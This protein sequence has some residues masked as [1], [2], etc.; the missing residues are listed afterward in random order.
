MLPAER[1]LAPDVEARYS[2]LDDL[3]DAWRGVSGFAGVRV[4]EQLA[5]WT[6]TEEAVGWLELGSPTK[7]IDLFENALE[8]DRQS[9]V[10]EAGLRRAFE[11]IG[12][13][14]GRVTSKR[15]SPG[16]PSGRHTAEHVEPEPR[17]RSVGPKPEEKGQ[18]LEA[19]RAFSE[20]LVMYRHARL[21]GTSDV[22]HLHG[23]R[24]L[25][26]SAR[27][28][29][30]GCRM[31]AASACRPIRSGPPKKRA[32]RRPLRPSRGSPSESPTA[33]PSKR[34]VMR[35]TG[36]VKHDACLV[37]I[38]DSS[39]R[40]SLRLTGCL[41]AQRSRVVLAPP[42]AIIGARPP[43]GHGHEHRGHRSPEVATENDSHVVLEG[44]GRK[45]NKLDQGAS[46]RGQLRT[47]R[48]AGDVLLLRITEQSIGRDD[49]RGVADRA[50]VEHE[51]QTPAADE[52]LPN[53]SIGE[54][55]DFVTNEPCPESPTLQPVMP[56]ESRDTTTAVVW[57]CPSRVTSRSSASI[58]P[59]QSV[60]RE[61]APPRR[62][63]PVRQQHRYPC[64]LPR[65]PRHHEA[66]RTHEH[67]RAVLSRDSRRDDFDDVLE[68]VFHDALRQR[69]RHVPHRIRCPCRSSAALA[70][71]PWPRRT[72][73]GLCRRSDAATS[74][75]ARSARRR[76]RQRSRRPSRWRR[77][78]GQ[79]RPARGPRSAMRINT[80]GT[81]Q[82]TRGPGE[83][84]RSGPPART[85]YARPR[86]PTSAPR[87]SGRRRRPSPSRLSNRRKRS[88]SL[89]PAP[90]GSSS[91]PAVR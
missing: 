28:G 77:R 8:L 70:L 57:P 5:S 46:R 23:A 75:A 25:Q 65:P 38:A 33:V 30:A 73:L 55:D 13:A 83:S 9:R 63:T 56:R 68:P 69:S 22:F 66:T 58:T 84:R 21:D 19:Q 71:L 47:A 90:S 91:V 76:A 60:S 14:G 79:L 59:L 42:P 32:A 64:H 6:L 72:T 41:R 4:G 7:A 34:P 1:S 20:A 11:M 40:T 43:V 74:S 50:S 78:S 16:K 39:W 51:R 61:V 48:D 49:Q 89:M 82:R 12:I 18:Q 3:R 52:R 88:W 44:T 67:A 81:P 87:S 24:A 53:L 37:E 29:N 10:A 62:R 45:T 15:S 36:P 54:V 85:D 26:S 86:D 31:R 2:T 35:S 17:S 80:R 27:H